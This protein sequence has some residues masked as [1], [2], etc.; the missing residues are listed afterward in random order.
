MSKEAHFPN[1]PSLNGLHLPIGHLYGVSQVAY[2]LNTRYALRSVRVEYK[3]K[4]LGHKIIEQLTA[5]MPNR[6]TIGAAGNTV[7]STASAHLTPGCLG[8]FGTAGAFTFTIPR[9]SPTVEAT[10]GD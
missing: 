5:D 8:I 2:L 4:H 3:T 6:G 7:I 1:L 9:A 10:L